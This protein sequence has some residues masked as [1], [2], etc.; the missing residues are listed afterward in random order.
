M[1]NFNKISFVLFL[2]LI[3]AAT[4]FFPHAPNFTAIGAM[5]LFGGAYLPK[6]TA[7][8]LPILAMAISDAFLG[9]YDLRMMAFV[10]G[11]FLI[12]VFMGFFLK[13]NKK[14]YSILAASFLSAFLFFVLTNFAVFIF[15]PWYEKTLSGLM[16]CYIMALPFFKNNLLGDIFYT[17]V[18]FGA[19][20]AA[21]FFV[22][23]KIKSSEALV[24]TN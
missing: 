7:L 14:L 23:K 18:F 12:C 11:S 24:N 1:K 4:R 22:A 21:R 2:I 15:T 6:K 17:G 13:K 5:A 16:Q 10:Y 20:E 19:F 3:G 8:I 9:F